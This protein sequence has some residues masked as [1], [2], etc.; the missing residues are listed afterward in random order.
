MAASKS[1]AG[2]LAIYFA[3]SIRGGRQ[4]A[5]L[6]AS[7][8]KHLQASYEVLTE[9]VA[10]PDIPE[11]GEVAKGGDSFIYKRDMCWLRKSAAVVAE[12]TQPSLGVGYELGQAEAMGI[13]VLCL[14]RPSPGKRL[15]AMLTG[16]PAMTIV[17]YGDA[18]AAA[19]ALDA[20]L[21]GLLTTGAE[22]SA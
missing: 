2:K 1:A 6:Y 13:P 19:A 5:E 10:S 11:S 8:V 4:D 20:A 14:Y 15:S 18:E 3:G 21:P 7:I 12:V 17:E 9:H 16:N 22:E